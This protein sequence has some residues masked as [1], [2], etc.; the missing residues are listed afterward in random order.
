MYHNVQRFALVLKVDIFF[1]VVLL[2]GVAIITQRLFF[3]I[4]TIVLAVSI[5]V[6]L[7][8]SRIAITRENHWLVYI[9]LSLQLAILGCN[10]YCIVGLIQY[11]NLWNIGLVYGELEPTFFFF[12]LMLIFNHHSSYCLNF[13]SRGNLFINRAHCYT[14][15]N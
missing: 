10:I 11:D 8:L 6:G 7:I 12:S 14:H 9:F 4:V 5:A 13:I 2:I 1:Q 15:I 3:R